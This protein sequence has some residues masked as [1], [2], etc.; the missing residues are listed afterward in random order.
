MPKV[1][2]ALLVYVEPRYYPLVAVLDNRLRT[3]EALA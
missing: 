3:V 1:M 2:V